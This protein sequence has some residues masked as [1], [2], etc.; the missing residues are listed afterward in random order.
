MK[1]HNWVSGYIWPKQLGKGVVNEKTGK[2]K[3]PITLDNKTFWVAEK[4]ITE[5]KLAKLGDL[6]EKGVQK[7]FVP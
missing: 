3:F 1:K 2:I 7:T 6:N 5:W 4:N